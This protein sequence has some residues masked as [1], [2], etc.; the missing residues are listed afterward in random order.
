MQMMLIG[1]HENPER[2]TPHL[3]TT[4]GSPHPSGPHPPGSTRSGPSE[5]ETRSDPAPAAASHL[6]RINLDVQGH[7]GNLVQIITVGGTVSGCN[8]S[9]APSRLWSLPDRACSC[10]AA[11][12]GYLSK[13]FDPGSQVPFILLLSICSSH[14]I[15]QILAS[16]GLIYVFI[17]RVYISYV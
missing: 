5:G 17:R 10:V 6:P 4:A 2:Y 15:F 12:L 3:P 9:S 11:A 14:D 16:I 1:G 8:L 7:I 13:Y